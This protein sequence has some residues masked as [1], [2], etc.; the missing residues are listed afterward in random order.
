MQEQNKFLVSVYRSRKMKLTIPK[1]KTKDLGEVLKTLFRKFCFSLIMFCTCLIAM[2]V[3]LLLA[4][5]FALLLGMIVGIDKRA[6]FR[7]AIDDEEY[8]I[9]KQLETGKFLNQCKNG[10]G[11]KKMQLLNSGGLK[12]LRKV[13]HTAVLCLKE[14]GVLLI[15]FFS[16]LI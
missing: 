15:S 7:H 8:K 12:G 1:R 3:N 6:G 5:S 2:K 13:G 14:E 11:K 10:Q 9:L 16:I 4:L